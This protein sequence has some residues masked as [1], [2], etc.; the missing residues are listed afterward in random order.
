MLP[1]YACVVPVWLLLL[2]IILAAHRLTRFVTR[3]EFP[4]VKATRDRIERRWGTDSWQNYL[5]QCA[6]CSSVYL[7]VPVAWTGL[8]VGDETWWQVSAVALA[9]STVVGFL[10]GWEHE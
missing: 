6:W 10:D 3:D 7:S 8:T 9:A 2:V 4:P 1:F 5:G